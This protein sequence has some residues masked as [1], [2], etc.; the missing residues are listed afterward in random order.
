MKK[1]IFQW[2]IHHCM[3]DLT[4]YV[5]RIVDASLGVH[6][7]WC[8]DNY[9]CTNWRNTTNHRFRKIVQ[10]VFLIFNYVSPM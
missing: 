4:L 3:I 2:H 5:T 9:P 10:D 6:Y 1:P 7:D 8:V